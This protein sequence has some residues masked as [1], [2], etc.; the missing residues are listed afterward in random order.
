MKKRISM[1]MLGLAG[2]LLGSQTLCFGQGA[3]GLIRGS[4]VDPQGGVILQATVT[5]VNIATG[6][7]RS[8][9][10]TD[11]GIYII[12]DLPPGDYEVRVDKSGFSRTVAKVHVNVGDVRDQ[13]FQLS[14]AGTETEVT[15][16]SDLTMVETT[17]TDVSTLVD[18]SQ[19]HDLP[20]TS[21]LAFQNVTSP[22][23]D[24]MN[25][26]TTA[27]GV[28]FDTSNNLGNDVIG[29]GAWNSRM[30]LINIDGGNMTD[31]TN[32]GRDVLGA[33]LDEV[34]EFQVLTNNYNAEYGQAGSLIVNVITKSGSNSFHGDGHAYFRG[35]NLEAANYFYNL[36]L[37]QQGIPVDG[38]RRAPFQK[39]EWGFTAGGPFIKDRTFW[40]GS[41]EKTHQAVPFTL[42]PPTGIITITQPFNEYMWSVKV[43]H[44]LT[45]N[46][47]LS[48]RFN[49]TRQ[50]AAN[51][52][53][54]TPV[55]A[56]PDDL[57]DSV[58]H[59]HTL[60]GSLTS[61]LTPHLVNEA[62]VFWHR[63]LSLTS[64]PTIAPAVKFPSYTSGANFCCPQ[65]N[66]ANRYEG[67]DNL[68]W[69]HG[70]HVVKT[71]VSMNYIPGIQGFQQFHFGQ[72]S[73][74]SA[75]VATGFTFAV[76]PSGVFAGPDGGVTPQKDN[77]YGLYV[78]DTWKIRP[79]INLNYGLRYDAE[80]GAFRGGSIPKPGGGCFQ[81]NGIISACSS[82]YN[83]FQ[84]R[85]G[86]SWSPFS[87][88]RTVVSASFAEVTMLAFMNVA[89]DSLNFDGVNLLTVTSTDPAVLAFC[90]PG[91]TNPVAPPQSLLG[92]A[93]AAK[94]A[95]GFFGRV[96][97]ISSHLKNPEIRHVNLSVR[98]EFTPSTAIE[99]DY[100]GVFGFGMYGEDDKNYP[101]IL[102]DPTASGFFFLGAR[103]DQ[104]FIAIRTNENSRS[105]HYNGFSAGAQRR[106]ANHLLFNLNYTWSKT[107]TSGE[108]FFGLSEPNVPHNFRPELAPATNDIR[109]LFNYSLV[110]DTTRLASGRFSNWLLNNW[111]LAFTGTVQ[112]GRPYPISTG[113]AALST[114][115]FPGL[116]SET[117]QRPN[118]LSDGTLSVLNIA[119]FDGSLPTTGPAGDFKFI[120]GN[121][122][123]NAG[124]GSGYGRLDF[125]LSRG[126]QL[127]H[128]EARRLEFKADFFNILNH[129]NF[130]SYNANDVLNVLAIGPHGC[131]RCVDASNGFIVGKDGRALHVNDMRGGPADK[132]FLNP[133]WGGIGDPVAADIPRQI[134]LAVRVR[135]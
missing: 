89:L 90:G 109:H 110:F 113:A 50:L 115:S 133:N 54:Q 15:V 75:G 55:N 40:F 66:S 59:D 1:L 119:N 93:V 36:G 121:V 42:A 73:A 122:G 77:I 44:K 39:N 10:T 101:A 41:F 80:A 6:V 20:V 124:L 123:R 26:A 130:L 45:N 33:S 126:F 82:D 3:T 98:H 81:K 21:N 32:S 22:S 31:Q 67:I 51:Q 61:A 63:L 30:T 53:T 34:Q 134:Q 86:I 131:T 107:L 12:P 132:D 127:G 28:K 17:R 74:T 108:D 71:G 92:P 57:T 43:D 9:Q 60:N 56:T 11:A 125:S 106:L 129:T 102:P 78:Q 7:A 79:S 64:D 27:P 23:N 112:S 4:V 105:S 48:F 8:T 13:N 104:R 16:T 114:S 84:P 62:R 120:G 52:S 116:G 37:A 46:H 111:A 47:T 94:R 72:Y 135:W 35:R 5:A 128:N 14:L 118:V 18:E 87:N 65:L 70:A 99:L 25:L 88:D 103:P 85:L 58:I 19:I 117:Q 24:Y 49:Q 91:C 76:G 96:R 69:T 97:P 95:A 83:N 29:P 38:A 68:T 2:L 100:I